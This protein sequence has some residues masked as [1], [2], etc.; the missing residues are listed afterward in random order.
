MALTVLSFRDSSTL[1][2]PLVPP[3]PPVLLILVVLPVVLLVLRPVL[4]M[5]RLEVLPL[6]PP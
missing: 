6:S 4:A 1:L 3:V 5:A 2:V